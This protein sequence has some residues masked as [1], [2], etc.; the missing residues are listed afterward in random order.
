MGVYIFCCEIQVHVLILDPGALLHKESGLPLLSTLCH[1]AR[2]E[3]LT[4]GGRA[5]VQGT[6]HPT[7]RERQPGRGSSALPRGARSEGDYVDFALS[8]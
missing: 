6:G 2:P 8:L 7:G 3:T 1:S 5:A 4:F